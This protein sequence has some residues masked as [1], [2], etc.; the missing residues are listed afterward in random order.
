MEIHT[1]LSLA[2]H[3]N[4]DLSLYILGQSMT[5]SMNSSKIVSLSICYDLPS[6][7]DKKSIGTQIVS[8]WGQSVRPLAHRW[9]CLASFL[10][11]C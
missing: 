5:L 1:I 7:V 9:S 11:L 4:F 3:S 6:R 10:Q 2:I 8:S